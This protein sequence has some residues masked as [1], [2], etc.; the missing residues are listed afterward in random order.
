MSGKERLLE[1][2]TAYCA[3]DR[4][5]AEI[6]RQ[7]E[8]CTEQDDG[9]PSIGDFGSARCGIAMEGQPESWCDAC[10][11]FSENA[12]KFSTGMR[13]RRL[14]KAKMLRAYAAAIRARKEG[15]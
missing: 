13:A 9:D 14:A 11:T 7:S 12:A 3:A 6:R 8:R 1:A 2:A 5:M 10:K 4:L 15:E